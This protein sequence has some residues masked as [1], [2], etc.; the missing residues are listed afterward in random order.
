MQLLTQL[1]LSS[2]N[3]MYSH[4][5]TA[6]ASH[7]KP[8]TASGTANDGFQPGTTASTTATAAHKRSTAST[9]STIREFRKGATAST[10]AID[11]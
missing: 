11:C 4:L 9:A 2:A 7:I 3:A 1:Q 5:T 8:T 6:T 10:T